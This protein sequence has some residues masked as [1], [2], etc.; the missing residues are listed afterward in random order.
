MGES[1]KVLVSKS[2]GDTRFC[3][4]YRKLNKFTVKDSYPLPRTDSV[5]DLLS[6]SKW[7]S[8]LDLASG[9]HQIEVHP[10]DREKT[11]FC[12]HQG[13]F[14]FDVMPY[15]LCNSP[16]TFQRL[17]DFL[18]AGLNWKM[19]LVYMDDICIFASS[20]ET[21]IERLNEVFE[22]LKRANLK[23][24]PSKC[25]LFHDRVVYL[26]HEISADGVLRNVSKIQVIKDWRTP[27]CIKEV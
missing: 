8:T 1:S 17:M 10:S 24:K 13:L 26:G 3:L 21:H 2:N 5:L 7:F 22:Q 4:D 11:A 27:T 19:C 9:F 14:E 18:L 23:L 6:G 16:S 20:F 12:T 25:K 15:G